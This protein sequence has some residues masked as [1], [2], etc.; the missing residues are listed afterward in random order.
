M[1]DLFRTL[2]LQLQLFNVQWLIIFIIHI[3]SCPLL[4]NIATITENSDND[5]SYIVQHRLQFQG[6]AQ[7]SNRNENRNNQ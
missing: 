3:H 6:F 4:K 1:V 7:I 2:K 5:N